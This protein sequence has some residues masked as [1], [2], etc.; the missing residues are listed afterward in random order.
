MNS[1]EPERTRVRVRRKVRIRIPHRK[2]STVRIAIGLAVLAVTVISVWAYLWRTG[3]VPGNQ[4][5]ANWYETEHKS[6]A[7]V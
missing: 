5:A 6:I 1:T 7:L 2:R 3:L 4:S